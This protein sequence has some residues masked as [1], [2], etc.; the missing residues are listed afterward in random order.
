MSGRSVDNRPKIRPARVPEAI[1]RR[2]QWLL[3][4]G[5]PGDDDRDKVPLR[6][7][8]PTD[9]SAGLSFDEALQGLDSPTSLGIGHKL[10]SGETLL[11]GFMIT[12]GD[13]FAMIDWD[14]VRDPTT[15][16]VPALVRDKMAE[17]GGYTEVS[18]SRAGFHQVGPISDTVVEQ[19]QEHE[20]K[21]GLPIGRVDTLEDPPHVEVYES[22]QY[23]T[24]T[25][26][27]C[28]VIAE[29]EYAT[30][31]GMSASVSDLL[32]RYFDKKSQSTTQSQG[33]G[34]NE[35]SLTELTEAVAQ[36]NQYDHRDIDGDWTEV[37]NPTPAQVWATGLA[38]S[39]DEFEPLWDG[40]DLGH[41]TT[42]EADMA[43]VSKLWFFGGD[44]ELVNQ[45]F[46]RSKR[47]RTK[48]L[49]ESYREATIRNTADNDRYDG[50]Y[51][52][53]ETV[54]WKP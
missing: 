39:D 14:D 47:M 33:V 18:V 29:P 10:R 30:M 51:L 50:Q 52:T 20:D 22:G 3:A 21:A 34:Y 9:A 26:R 42:S 2:D 48:W 16:H 43:F 4:R 49:T 17:T 46:R 36:K 45:C 12:S 25:G 35:P 23:M 24:V 27:A 8:D 32:D 37:D 1:C 44:R 41:P 54:P 31:D 40:Q 11:L 38:L 19:I 15:G 6:P 13:P 53:P 5:S 7:W 28:D